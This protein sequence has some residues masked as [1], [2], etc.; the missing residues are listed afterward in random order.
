MAYGTQAKQLTASGVAS[1]KRAF[2]RQVCTVH[3]A[4]GDAEVLLYDMTSAPSESDVPHCAVPMFGKNVQTIAIPGDGI[5]FE[6]G[7]YVVVPADTAANI[8]YEE[9]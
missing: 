7:I 4:S 6:N 2:L 1:G 5:L 8:F 3:D 9:A